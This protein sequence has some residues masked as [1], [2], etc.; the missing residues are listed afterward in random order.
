MLPSQRYVLVDARALGAQDLPTQNRFGLCEARIPA[1]RGIRRR[2]CTRDLAPAVGS[3]DDA[4]ADGGAEGWFEAIGGFEVE[5]AHFVV[6]NQP[7]LFEQDAGR[8]ESGAPPLVNVVHERLGL[9]LG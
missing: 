3:G 7:P 4:V 6:A 9:L 8:G 5:G 1:S 2:R